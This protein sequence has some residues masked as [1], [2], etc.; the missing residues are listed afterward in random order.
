MKRFLFL[1][2]VLLILASCGTT[3]GVVKA[4]KKAGPGVLQNEKVIVFAGAAQ[5]KNPS[6]GAYWG[7]AFVHILEGGLFSYPIYGAAAI[8][9]FKIG[10]KTIAEE[11]PALQA[12]W[13]DQ[14]A[15]NFSSAYRRQ[16]GGD[17]E[18][19]PYP[20]EKKIKLSYFSGANAAVKS[21][22]SKLCAENQARY[23]VGIV[24]QVVHGTGGGRSMAIGTQIK[25]EVCV[26]DSNGKIVARGKTATPMLMVQPSSLGS[27]MQLYAAGEVNTESLIGQLAKTK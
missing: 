27:Y 12:A 18:T 16:F 7:Q 13:I 22:I 11:L 24:T 26:F 8:G 23:A 1:G 19:V 14:F 9:D 15:E 21:A 4:T 3:T 25:T 20:F 17:A 2:T 5:R 10:D 6:M